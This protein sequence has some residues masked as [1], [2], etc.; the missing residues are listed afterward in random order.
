MGKKE[1][2]KGGGGGIRAETGASTYCARCKLMRLSAPKLRKVSKIVD[3]SLK[4][5]W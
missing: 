5:W 4:Y 1:K 2:E 3:S